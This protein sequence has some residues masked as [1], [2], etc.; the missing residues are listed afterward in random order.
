MQHILSLWDVVKQVL[1]GQS[2]IL[3]T[4]LVK[5]KPPIVMKSICPLINYFEGKLRELEERKL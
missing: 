4:M 3:M 1:R 2:M 5:E